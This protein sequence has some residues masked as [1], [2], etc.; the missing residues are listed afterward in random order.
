MAKN[1]IKHK[2]LYCELYTNFEI[3][4]VKNMISEYFSVDLV[5]AEDRHIDALNKFCDNVVSS[6]YYKHFIDEYKQ[7]HSNNSYS[8][9][10]L[11]PIMKRE[12][13]TGN[14]YSIDVIENFKHAY[15]YW[16]KYLL[17]HGIDMVVFS[18][19][20]H[21]IPSLI[22]YDLCKK[23]HIFKVIIEKTVWNNQLVLFEDFT[24]NEYFINTN[25]IDD[26]NF[27]LETLM[28][29]QPYWPNIKNKIHSE[30]KKLKFDL[31]KLKNKFAVLNQMSLSPG[32]Y[33]GRYYYLNDVNSM[34]KIKRFWIKSKIKVNRYR[35]LQEYQKLF[36]EI[37]EIKCKFIVYFLQCE[38]EK[39]D[40]PLGGKYHNQLHA[41]KTLL[42]WLPDG[43]LLAVKE[44]PSQ[45]KKWQRLEYGR[46]VGFYNKIQTMGCTII[47]H[48]TDNKV[49][50]Q[51]SSAII[52]LSGTVVFEAY[53]QNC[54]A[55]YM[56]YP[57]YRIYNCIP[58]I[59][60]REKLVELMSKKH[61][62]NT[63]NITNTMQ[64]YNFIGCNN[65]F[66][67]DSCGEMGKE[68]S[69]HLSDAII[70]KYKEWN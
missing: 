57:W 16:E 51:K 37:N 29:H 19:V 47:N 22:I 54:P 39:G 23:L 69:K 9:D 60:H 27:N 7:S 4:L 21:S 67:E 41:I 58:K 66:A 61:F 55:G 14:I 26:I 68:H 35:I 63:N 28:E 53:M 52:S 1:K 36:V 50:F 43:Y 42:N 17:N 24:S 31:Y 46:S 5:I 45:F 33:D 2:L 64:K 18:S 15:A 49:I 56:G 3:S 34:L 59:D 6:N 44:H 20:P 30:N 8:I 32:I 40:F 25:N 13:R 11:L 12:H 70:T 48:T 62:V 65:V 38:P 10:D